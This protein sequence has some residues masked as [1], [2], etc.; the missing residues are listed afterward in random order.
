MTFQ[1]R[2]P[3]RL[4]DYDYSTPNTYFVTV[5]TLN[6]QCLF[7]HITP[8]D[9]LSIPTMTLSSLGILT[10][11]AILQIPAKYNGVTLDKFVIMPNHI[12]ML[13]TQNDS[14]VTLSA[15]ISRLK[16]HV[17]KQAGQPVWQQSFHDHIVRD[18]KPYDT[19]WEYIDTNPQKWIDDVYHKE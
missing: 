10:R 12:H 19:V 15:I 17:T 6:K 7:G 1:T 18:Q 14:A 11:T 9:N 4:P 8:T 13:I 2:K 5:C 16:S 3:N